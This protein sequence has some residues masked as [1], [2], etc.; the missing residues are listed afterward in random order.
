VHVLQG[1]EKEII[2]FSSVLSVGDSTTF[3]NSQYNMLNVAVSRAKHSFLFFGNMTVLN[4]S[5][6]DPL[7]NLKIWL[8]KG[9]NC[10]LSNKIVYEKDIIHKKSVR[11]INSLK[12]H[13]AYLKRAFEAAES[14]LIIVSPFISINA[15]ENDDIVNLAKAS[16]GR[17]VKVKVFTDSMLDIRNGALKSYSAKDRNALKKCG[18]ELKIT[19]AIHNKTLIVDD[20]IIIEGSFNWLSTT[21]DESSDFFRHETSIFLKDD[22]AKDFIVSAKEYL[23]AN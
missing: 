4:A 13:R 23:N 10:E 7:G 18:V 20:N 14:E 16:I 8:S 17:G 15:I 9:E 22:E 19:K 3:I 11:R 2:I 5:R 21:R 12:D 1:A 6:N